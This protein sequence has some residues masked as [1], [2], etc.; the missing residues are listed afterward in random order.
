MLRTLTAYPNQRR[1]LDL[2]L[3]NGSFAARVKAGS[4]GNMYKVIV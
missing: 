2:R 4:G 3:G 1:P